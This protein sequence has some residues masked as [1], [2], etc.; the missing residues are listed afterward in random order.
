MYKI[1]QDTYQAN[2]N[3]AQAQLDKAEALLTK[4]TKDWKRAEKLFASKSISEQ[5]KDDYL[6]TYQDA[7]ADVKN[8]KAKVQD[9]KIN[10]QYTLI[11]SPINGLTGK[12]AFDEGN[13]V[14]SNE[15]N[16]KLLTITNTNPVYIEFSLPQKDIAKYLDQIKKGSVSFSISANGKTYSDGKLN[17]VSSK[18]D[19]A[20]DSL[21]L[22][23]TFGNKNNELIIGGYST[24]EIKI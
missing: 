23:T 5:S 15:N 18:I 11:R 10:Y 21:L 20:T 2:L 24:I 9:A 22:R 6:Y 8:Y 3:A 16:S 17:F 19:I 14:G 7:L 13:Y 12:S 4:A 1:E